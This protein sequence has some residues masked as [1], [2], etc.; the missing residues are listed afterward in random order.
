MHVRALVQRDLFALQVS[1]RFD[2]A[3]LWDK[4]GLASWRGRLVAHVN[5]RRACRLGK[6]G[7]RLAS[8]AEIDGANIQRLQEL[9]PGRKLDPGDFIAKRR[10]LLLKRA[11]AFQ[12]DQ[13]TEFLEPYTQRFLLS[14]CA[15]RHRKRRKRKGGAEDPLP[16]RTAHP[17]LH[18]KGLKAGQPLQAP[19]HQSA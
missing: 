1:Q 14:L 11:P 12:Q 9:R 17:C 7:R 4:D 6:N 15:G 10:R 19:M 3:I 13:L 8:I 16:D 5:E 2:W 18:K